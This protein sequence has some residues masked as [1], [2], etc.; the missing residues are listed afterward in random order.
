M[1]FGS[2]EELIMSPRMTHICLHVKDV[3]ECTRFYKDYCKLQTI[4][5]RINEGEGSVYM[6]EVGR[7]AEIVFQL[8]SGGNNLTLAADE[9]RH[10]GFVVESK[11]TVDDIAK[12]ARED[13]ILFFEP[14]EYLP[15]AYMCGVKDPNG[16]CI[17]FS[18][19]HSVPPITG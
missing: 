17:E 8:K 1:D 4:D 2:V 19:G 14:E 5:E 15:G 11:Q 9:E 13:G 10:F 12:R 6:A 18:Y 16:N 3:D 7:Q